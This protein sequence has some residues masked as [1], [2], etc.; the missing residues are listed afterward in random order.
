[1][2]GLDCLVLYTGLMLHF[3]KWTYWWK[4]KQVVP[5]KWMG[6]S[7]VCS[8]CGLMQKHVWEDNWTLIWNWETVG[9]V[10]RARQV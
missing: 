9:K 3:H 10:P 2:A 4:G 7:R 6:D 5:K 1:M 8:S